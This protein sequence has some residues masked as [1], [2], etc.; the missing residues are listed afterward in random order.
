MMGGS[1]LQVKV[2]DTLW[3]SKPHPAGRYI[4]RVT[5]KQYWESGIVEIRANETTTVVPDNYLPASVSVTVMDEGGKPLQNALFTRATGEYAAF[6]F[7]RLVPVAGMK[8]YTDASGQARLEGL[9]AGRHDF[10]IE[11][12]G[13]EPHRLELTLAEGATE[14]G[15]QVFLKVA[16]GTITVRL[17]G[18]Q[19]GQTYTIWIMQP[20]GVPVREKRGAEFETEFVRLA[21]RTYTIG[22]SPSKGGQA[23]SQVV[24]LAPGASDQVVD[25]DVPIARVRA[26]ALQRRICE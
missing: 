12:E 5:G 22:V 24:T 13:Y 18:M 8:A 21:L 15:I 20:R 16:V 1:T 17:H 4:V 26:L 11:A 6:L 3:R 9:R 10:S 14:S 7:R 23:A 25:L 19:E 2:S